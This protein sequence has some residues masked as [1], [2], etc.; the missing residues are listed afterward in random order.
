MKRRLA[1]AATVL[2]VGALG[3]VPPAHAQAG[4]TIRSFAVTLEIQSDGSL[5]VTERIRYDFG[6]ADRHGI[7]RDIPVRYEYEPDPKFER[8]LRISDVS[9]S[10][11]AG[12]PANLKI[13][14]SGRLKRFRIGDPDTTISGVHDYVI[15]YTV[16]GALNAFDDHDELFWNATGNEWAAPIDTAA[17]EVR[18]P[19]AISQ[20]ACYQ[21]AT[22]SRLTCA[23][24]TSDGSR[25]TFAEGNLGP[26]EGVT[27]VV[28]LPK[29]TVNVPPPILDE[30][31]SFERAFEVSPL[32]VGLSTGVLGVAGIGVF[33][34]LR[35]GRDRRWAGSP[36]DVVFGNEV[37]REEAV[38]LFGRPSDPVEYEPPDVGGNR[39]RPGQ[40]GTLVDE[41]ANPLDVT[42]TIVDLAVRG[43]LRIEEEP[44]K[45]WFGK[46][47]WVLTKLKE[48]D[49]LL[50]YEKKLHDG[51]FKGGHVVE[52]SDLKRKFANRLKDVQ[53]ALY[54]DAIDAGWFS[55]RPD[56]VRLAWRAVG[57]VAVIVAFVVAVLLVA[58]T[59]LGLLGL[60]LVLCSLVLLFGAGRMPRRTPQGYAALRRVTGFRRFIEESE[61]ERARFAERANLFSEY[62]PYAI[63][64]GATEKWAKAFSG[65]ED[66]LAASTAGWYVSDRPFS[67]GAFSDSM[68]SFA[69]TTSGTIVATAASSGSSGFSGGGSSGG[70]FGG[71]GGGSW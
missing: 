4:E 56:K 61:K 31:W 21:G 60:P 71:G 7:L 6:F 53:N 69:I 2:L 19:G 23:T 44:K 22:G 1:L 40:V 54:E 13:E 35:K 48:P 42:A 27:V 41:V 24:A 55:G 52:L 59:H 30:K 47:D 28:G 38:P 63:V 58:L 8:V 51:L 9:V 65:L 11:S 12:T 70:G 57:V 3:T 5:R 62:L 26:F 34:L 45:G 46:G 50:R 29:G 25:A 64:F 33:Q 43:Y 37:G 32:T 14:D 20:V 67:T 68:D 66:E 16:R 17:V 36:V 10:A 15:A 18:A 39:V 49:D